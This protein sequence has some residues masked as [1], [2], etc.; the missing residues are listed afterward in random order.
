MGMAASC[1]LDWAGAKQRGE[2]RLV[3]NGEMIAFYDLIKLDTNRS[4]DVYLSFALSLSLPVI[5]CSFHSLSF[6]GSCSHASVG[7]MG[8]IYE[9]YATQAAKLTG[10]W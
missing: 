6:F 5:L 4:V 8:H 1:G 2:P 10:I 7:F 3:A 9:K